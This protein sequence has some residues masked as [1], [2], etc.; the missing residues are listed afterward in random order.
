MVKSLSIAAAEVLFL[1]VVPPTRGADAISVQTLLTGLSNPC[2]VAIRPSESTEHYEVFVAESGA[3]RI[4]RV[5]SDAEKSNAAD[6][7]TGFSLTELGDDGLPVGP[8]G[9]V[10]LDR[11]RLVVG[12]SNANSASLKLFELADDAASLHADDAKQEVKLNSAREIPNHVYAIARTRAN[13]TV[14]DALVVT[15]FDNGQSGDLRTVGLR[16]DTFAESAPFEESANSRSESPAAIAVGEGGYVV[17][18]WVG[19]L[20]TPRDSRLAFYNPANGRQLMELATDLH[21]IL[22]LAYS[23]RTESLYAADASWMDAKN[24]GVFRIDAATERRPAKCSV[25]KI[26]EIVRPSAL[27]FGPDGAMYV[28]AFGELDKESAEGIL[29]KISGD[30]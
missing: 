27:T 9:L 5:A 7:I 2:G 21:D 16:A 12:V 15:R 11:R 24:G 4:V 25:M 14:R 19:S 30:L 20:G 6:V 3:G 1:L 22:G 8:I 17:V 26:A 13:D 23:P 18:G 28:T 10:F 29:V